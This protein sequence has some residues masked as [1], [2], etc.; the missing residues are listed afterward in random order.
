M[1]LINY[2]ISRSWNGIICLGLGLLISLNLA[3]PSQAHWADLAVAE[4][5][6]QERDV[7]I[8]LTLPTGLVSQF[9]DDRNRQLSDE[10]ITKHAT[11]LQ[12]FFDEKIRLAAGA[13][14]TGT[15]TVQSGVAKTL[16]SNL[17]A[18]PILIAP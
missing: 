5:Q 2:K 13:Q 10:E 4:I 9:D 18:T 1:S 12:K 14:K 11:E 15:L 17:N 16:P 8:D 3:L 6:I 7:T